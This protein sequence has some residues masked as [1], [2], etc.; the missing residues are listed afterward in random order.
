M[1]TETPAAV[2]KLLRRCLAKERRRR[3]PDIGMARFEIDDAIAA[4]ATDGTS[5]VVVAQLQVWQRPMPLAAGLLALL[6][7]TGVCVWRITP[8]SPPAAVTRTLMSLAPASRIPMNNNTLNMAISRDGRWLAYVGGGTLARDGQLYLRN[9]AEGEARAISGTLGA[10]YPFFSPD[11]QYSGD[12]EGPC[13]SCRACGRQ[14]RVHKSLGK[15]APPV[16]HSSHRGY[17]SS[18]GHDVTES[19]NPATKPGQA[20]SAKSLAARHEREH[21]WLASTILPPWHRPGKLHTG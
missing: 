13:G 17:S 6:V 9:L 4:P 10:L 2:Q 5:P 7:I 1:P 15:R 11:S 18:T 19:V 8:S 3:V 16:S 14:E 20:Q 21:Q 12:A